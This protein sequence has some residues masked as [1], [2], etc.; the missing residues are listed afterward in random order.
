MKLNYKWLTSI[1]MATLFLFTACQKEEVET[2]DSNESKVYFQVQNY[3]NSNGMVGYTTQTS[4]SFVG[5]KENFTSVIFKGT[6][7]LLGK[8]EDYDRK[9]SITIDRENTT[10][11]EGEDYEIDLDTVAIK[12]GE[13][14]A[15]IGVRFLRNASIRAQ[16]EKLVLKLEPN[17]NFT[18]L[19]KYKSVN[20]WS[21]TTADYLDIHYRRSLQR[22]GKLGYVESRKLFRCMER[23]QIYFYQQ[24]LRILTRRLGLYQWSRF[25]DYRRTY[26]LLC[27]STTKRVTEKGGRSRIISR[28]G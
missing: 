3:A 15:K 22:T 5:A 14:Q 24:F 16:K 13:S 1:I 2:Y 11:T 12:A 28:T 21:N 25:Q 20:T 17:E 26:A 6:I 27:P 18:I 4:Y 19:E 9:V 7:Q 10:M 23:R 8:V